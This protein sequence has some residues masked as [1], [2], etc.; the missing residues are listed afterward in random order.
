[1]E[2]FDKIRVKDKDIECT[3]ENTSLYTHLGKYAL[4]DHVFVRTHDDGGAFVW[5]HH[6]QFDELADKCITNDCLA[7]MN[8]K[9][10][11]ERDVETYVKHALEDS[12]QVDKILEQWSDADE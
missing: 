10:P 9:E 3:Q 6:S 11:N 8:Q 4:Y 7:I 1:M 12:D 5:R 2:A